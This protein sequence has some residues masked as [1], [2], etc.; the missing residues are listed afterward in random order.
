M[1]GRHQWTTDNYLYLN[2]STFMIYTIGRIT[3]NLLHIAQL[4]LDGNT[5]NTSVQENI[6][7]VSIQH[8]RRACI[9]IRDIRAEFAYFAATYKCNPWRVRC[10]F[11]YHTWRVHCTEYKFGFGIL[12]IVII[13]YQSCCA[14]NEMPPLRCSAGVFSPN[15]FKYV[16]KFNFI[17]E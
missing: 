17:V 1:N 6:P 13:E 3:C 16:V 10:E 4:R 11:S 12:R 5:R 15:Y 14:D 2:A 8:R 7:G 9:L